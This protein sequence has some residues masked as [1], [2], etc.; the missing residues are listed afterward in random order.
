MFG[1]TGVVFKTRLR[2]YGYTLV[3]K[4]VQA[5]DADALVAEAAIY[6]HCRSFQGVYIP[7]HLSAIELVVPYY[8]QSL[9]VVRHMMLMSWAGTSL[10]RADI[11]E[12]ID[13]DY[14]I[15]SI[16]EQ[17]GSAGISNGDWRDANL[18][19]NEELKRVMAIDF[20]L[21]YVTPPV[22]TKRPHESDSS[23]ERETRVRKTRRESSRAG[24]MYH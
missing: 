5:G 4:G 12:N 1:E 9:A 14:E 13:L 18:A 17:L 6:S 20:N 15:D 16:V 8:T 23:G 21:A 22:A 3:A 19:W 24:H 11:P 7:V 10:N 2:E